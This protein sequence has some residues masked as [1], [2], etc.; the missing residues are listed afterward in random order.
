M[1]SASPTGPATAS[2]EASPVA[3]I[4]D[5]GVV[6]APHRTEQTDERC[7]RSDR[8]EHGQA[9]F[10]AHALAR[11][12]LAQCAVD[13]LG[14]IQRLDQ[15]AA[16]MALMVR[17]GRGA[18]ERDLRERLGLRLLFHE[19]NRVLCRRRLPERLDDLLHAAPESSRCAGSSQ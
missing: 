9:A 2:I 5:Q 16:F 11:H 3:P 8:G 4:A 14:T 12:G 15:A 18:I 7:G 1:I 17:G 19:A 10:E 13:E 6:D